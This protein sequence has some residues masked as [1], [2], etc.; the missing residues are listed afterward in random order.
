MNFF[1]HVVI[2]TQ[3]PIDLTPQTYTSNTVR[4]GLS[5]VPGVH[6][7]VTKHQIADPQTAIRQYTKPANKKFKTH[8]RTGTNTR[9][10]QQAA[11][12]PNERTNE[13]TN[14]NNRT[15]IATHNQQANNPKRTTPEEQQ[16]RE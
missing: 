12:Q 16:Q 9:M 13:Q 8:K 3:L 1:R 14:Q 7:T 2:Q 11:N 6:S 5:L 4:L 15:N 10:N